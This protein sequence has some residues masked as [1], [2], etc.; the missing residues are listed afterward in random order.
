M[1]SITKS[2]KLFFIS[3]IIIISLFI[4]FKKSNLMSK[5]KMKITESSKF[6]NAFNN[7]ANK[8]KTKIT[9]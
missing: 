4:G 6:S 7:E 5:D 2:G 8:N 3:L 1:I 9:I